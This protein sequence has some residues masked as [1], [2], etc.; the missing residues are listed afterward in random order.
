MFYSLT[1]C[2]LTYHKAVDPTCAPRYSRRRLCSA[3]CR[4]GSWNSPRRMSIAILT[5][6]N[7]ARRPEA[8]W[9]EER[10]E[11]RKICE[12]IYVSRSSY[13]ERFNRW[14]R[15]LKFNSYDPLYLFCHMT[16]GSASK[17][18]MS[19]IFRFETT[20]GWGVVKSQPTWAKKKPLFALWGS[21]SVSL[22]L[23]C[24]LWSSAHRYTCFCRRLEIFNSKLEKR[25]LQNQCNWNFLG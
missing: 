11:E 25:Q 21:A 4:N 15:L 1:N 18:L 14:K 3:W 12:Q 9:S 22:Y 19:T 6:N 24:T 10:I 16:I 5:K 23:W 17:S 2:L 13:E 20:S 7:M 8:Q